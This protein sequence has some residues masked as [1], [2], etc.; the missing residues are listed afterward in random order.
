MHALN[1][2]AGV[3]DDLTYNRWAMEL[4]G[5]AHRASVC[6]PAAGGAP[7]MYWK[8]SAEVQY[9]VLGRQTVSDI[10]VVAREGR[11]ALAPLFVEHT[12]SCLIDTVIEGYAGTAWADDVRAP[13][14]AMLTYADVVIYGGDAAHPAARELARRLPIFK[15]VLP[16]P[17]GWRAL[18]EGMYGKRVV[19]LERYAFSD[20]S[21]DLARLRSLAQRVP[22]G[23]EL[24]RIDLD[25]ARRIVSVEGPVVEDHVRNLGSAADFVARGAGFVVLCGDEIVSAVSSYAACDRGIEVQVNTAEEYRRRGL[26]TAAS[27]RLIADCLECGMEAH[28]DAANEE[29]AALAKRLGYTPAGKYEILLRVA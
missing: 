25:I 28:W 27:A 12:P 15:G 16:S 10:E 23:F 17:G 8:M 7:R 26:A 9:G 18:C 6:R 4:A 21:L 24:R 22:V 5:R 14:V 20:E 29:S 3:L 19:A 13:R 1:R 11:K 2:A